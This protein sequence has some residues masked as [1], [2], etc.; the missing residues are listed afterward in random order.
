MR[1]DQKLYTVRRDMSGDNVLEI[2]IIYMQV[3]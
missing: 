1:I 3:V 2:Y